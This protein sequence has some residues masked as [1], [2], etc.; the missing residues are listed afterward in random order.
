MP[1]KIGKF[2]FVNNF[3]PYYWLEQK[4][5]RIIEASPLHIAVAVENDVNIFITTDDDIIKRRGC[6]S[7]WVEVENP[8]EV[9]G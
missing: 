6:I 2:G 1:A 7:K 5:V 4:G 3:L 9:N 8:K